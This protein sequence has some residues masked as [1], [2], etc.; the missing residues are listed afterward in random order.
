MQKKV[1]LRQM[2]WLLQNKISFGMDWSACG[3]IGPLVS[4]Y[5]TFVATLVA[6]NH[7]TLGH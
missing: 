7:D 5:V 6:Y 3:A 2:V 1:V 4:L